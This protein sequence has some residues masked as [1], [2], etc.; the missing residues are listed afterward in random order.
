[1]SWVAFDIINVPLHA[2]QTAFDLLLS[3][4]CKLSGAPAQLCLCAPLDRLQTLLLYP[5]C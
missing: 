4:F 1:M 3:P 5:I 2:W